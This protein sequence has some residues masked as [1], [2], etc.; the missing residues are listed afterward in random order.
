MPLR[1]EWSQGSQIAVDDAVLVGEVHRMGERFEKTGGVLGHLR[2]A[3]E[4]LIQRRPIDVFQRK[5]GE[6]IT[7][8]DL[9]DLHDVGVLQ[10][11]NGLRLDLEAGQLL[12]AGMATGKD[13]LQ[14]H[15]TVEF[16]LPR[17]VDDSHSPAAEFA[18]NVVATDIRNL[19]SGDRIN[20]RADRGALERGVA[21]HPGRRKREGGPTVAIPMEGE[22]GAA[23]ES[24]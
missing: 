9:V 1:F 23:V 17:L 7:F 18:K 20:R 6:R 22:R 16:P 19:A 3:G 10:S 11:G 21:G 15:Q 13:H 24:S 2:L 8:A 5:M 12:G 14:R 4:R